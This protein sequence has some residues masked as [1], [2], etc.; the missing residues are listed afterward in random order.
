MLNKQKIT[1]NYTNI[2]TY[3]ALGCNHNPMSQKGCQTMKKN[4]QN[5]INIYI[6]SFKAM[7]I[8]A[9]YFFPFI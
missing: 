9:S 5:W 3:W 2:Y 4:N 6:L 8:M 7:T 1:G